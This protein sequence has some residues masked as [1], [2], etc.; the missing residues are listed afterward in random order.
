MNVENSRPVHTCAQQFKEHRMFKKHLI[1]YFNPEYIIQNL[2]TIKTWSTQNKIAY[3]MF[4]T[5][6]VKLNIIYNCML[7]SSRGKC[8]LPKAYGRKYLFTNYVLPNAT[9]IYFAKLM[10]PSHFLYKDRYNCWI[11]SDQNTQCFIILSS[12]CSW[13]DMS[14]MSTAK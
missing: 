13:F 5:W 9:L 6:Q 7:L 8:I 1:F 2:N 4:L 10:N 11:F 14:L 12:I 3:R